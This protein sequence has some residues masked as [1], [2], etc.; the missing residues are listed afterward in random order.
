MQVEV[1]L[2]GGFAVVVDGATTPT[3]GWSRRAGAELVK[4]L[5]LSPGGRVHRDLV[6][7]TL[8]PGLTL[9]AAL[10]RLHK[11]AHHAR[12]AL[13][14][15]SAI[16]VRHEMVV[17]CP[18]GEVVV[19][20]VAFEAAARAALAEHP[21]SADRCAAVL[22]RAGELLPEDRSVPWLE[23][24]RDRLRLLTVQLARAARRWEEVLRLDPVD[25]EAHTELIRETLA[26]GNR[27]EALRRFDR[28]QR[29][30]AG[31]LGVAPSGPALA[32]HAEAMASSATATPR[33][34]VPAAP[35]SGDARAGGLLVEREVALDELTSICRSAI[36][37]RRGVVVVVP[38][39]AGAGKTTLV[40]AL[41]ERLHDEVAVLSGGCDDLLAPRSLGP[42]RDMAEHHPGLAAALSRGHLEDVLPAVLATVTAAPTLMVIEDVHW[43]D[44]ASLDVI[45]YLARRLVDVAAALVVTIRDTDLPADHP[46]RQVLGGLT[47]LPVRRISVDP[48]SVE[49]VRRLG[50]ASSEQ[51][52][53]IV[54]VTAG[55]PFFVTEVLA[56]HD[57]GVPPTVRDAV[58]ARVG[59]LSP[60]V[61]ALLRRLAV[62]P[63]RA[64]RTLAMR[65]ADD[66]RA[67]VVEAERSGVVASGTDWV[68][69]R[70]EL[71]RQ[72]IEVS[73]LPSER[74]DA[75]TLVAQALLSEP[76]VEPARVVHHAARAG[77][78]DLIQ[79]YG[80]RAAA[81]ASAL[82]SHRQAA[83]I[84]RVALE[85]TRDAREIAELSTRRAY[86]LYVVN[87]FAEALACA[88]G[89]VAAAE[90]AADHVLLADALLVSSRAALFARGPARARHAAERALRLLDDVADDTRRTA[91]LI[92]L[93]RA[94]SNLPTVGIVS[95]PC[96]R[97]G[98]L[99]EQARGLAQQLHRTDLAAFALCYRGDARLATGD[100][101]GAEDLEQGIELARSDSRAETLVRAYANAAGGAY[102]AGRHGQAQ[103]Y[104]A[105]GLQAAADGEFAAGQY[106]LR[107]TAATLDASQGDWDTAIVELRGLIGTP[108]EPGAMAVL[109]HAVLAR[110]LARRGDPAA[111]STLQIALGSPEFADDPLV[112][113][114]LAVAS[115]ECGWLD[116]SLGDLT[117]ATRRALEMTNGVY[118]AVHA[119]LCAYLRRAGV[120][121]ATPRHAPGP[122]GPTLA[123]RWE[124]AAPAWAGLGER[125]E[126]AVVLATA[127]DAAARDTGVGMLRALGAVASLP[128]V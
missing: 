61:R 45:R 125:Y 109:A 6:I 35:W 47:G 55:N 34:E 83:E 110:L 41:T 79:E 96:T 72:A 103:Q 24:P 117:P 25:E 92:E 23:Q 75:D 69:F 124:Q 87:R 77:L 49:A 112:T 111:V 95:E 27:S 17:L 20:A 107:L 120:P 16:I 90:T 89:A 102:R 57:A 67:V 68:A 56:T 14:Q 80:P 19:D 99:S 78:T 126:Q 32:L 3:G 39:E 8:W 91:A 105:A 29:L 128:A 118:P 113:G 108:G 63:S 64:S 85:H 74:I 60:E 44:D 7:D 18:D 73:L 86:S 121:V 42:F 100:P 38:G 13:G 59:R 115:T 48:L 4:L 54:R 93:A 62:V 97:A 43:A 22:A 66:D 50:A 98:E 70:H 26:R 2:L 94:H 10:P 12:S 33:P 30:L 52:A 82:G 53:E 123:G 65:L 116:G 36:R 101:R 46:V 84:L 1:R 104:V 88:E 114:V 106:R 5:A 122:W 127:P 28:M 40:R 21:V 76:A 11:A 9:E 58:L 71:A 37:E 51:A 31:E 119:E 15:R 81:E